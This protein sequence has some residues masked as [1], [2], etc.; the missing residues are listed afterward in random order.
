M[1]CAPRARTFTRRI[2]L[3]AAATL[4]LSPRSPKEVE[5]QGKNSSRS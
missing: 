1:K 5:D 3:R 4:M 2:L